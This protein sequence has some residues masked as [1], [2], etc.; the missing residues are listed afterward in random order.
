MELEELMLSVAIRTA[1]YIRPLGDELLTIAGR[2]YMAA[3][4]ND[5]CD[6]K[7]FFFFYFFLLSIS[8]FSYVY[9]ASHRAKLPV[10]DCYEV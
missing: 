5:F 3:R 4:T 9:F 10:T 7:L 8:A 1:L 2:F 6:G